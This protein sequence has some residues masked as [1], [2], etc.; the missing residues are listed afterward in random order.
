MERKNENQTYKMN[1][2]SL[3]NLSMTISKSW[4][5]S[6]SILTGGIIT[7]AY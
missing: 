3:E 4:I 1:N 7:C 2:S 5:I 6:C